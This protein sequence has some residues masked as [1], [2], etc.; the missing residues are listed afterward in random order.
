M[1]G[2]VLVC[3]QELITVKFGASVWE[4]VLIRTGQTKYTLFAA[5]SDVED[6]LAIGL[7][8]SVCAELN[9]TLQQAADAFGDYWVNTYSPRLYEGFYA[10]HTS[11]RT[12]LTDLNNMHA[13]LT[14]SMP[15][16]RPP[17]FR[18]E[19]PDPDTLLMHYESHRP[20]IDIAVGM[21]RALGTRFKETLV[22]EKVSPTSLTVRFPPLSPPA[23]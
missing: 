20:L 13:R 18:F 5:L 16:A 19:W 4:R 11:S 7:V 3:L 14:R 21:T 9:I 10:K 8:M 22:V 2:T 17:K 12:F 15:G 1:K 6:D 23:A